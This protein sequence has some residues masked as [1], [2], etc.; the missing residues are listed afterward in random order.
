VGCVVVGLV[1]WLVGCLVCWLVG[2]LYG[3]F[4]GCLLVGLVGGPDSWLVGFVG[5][6]VGQSLYVKSDGAR[7]T[8]R[9][10][11]VQCRAVYISITPLTDQLS[12]FAEDMD[13]SIRYDYNVERKKAKEKEYMVPKKFVV[14]LDAKGMTVHLENLFNG[15]RLLGKLV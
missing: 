5:W 11:T 6:L 15:N 4:I 9:K 3:G 14:T 1:G 13:V 2:W 8:S 10:K 12:L 7:H